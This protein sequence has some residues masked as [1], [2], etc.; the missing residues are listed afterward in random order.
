MDTIHEDLGITN[1]S[2]KTTM[3]VGGNIDYTV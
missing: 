3:V 2:R 1:P